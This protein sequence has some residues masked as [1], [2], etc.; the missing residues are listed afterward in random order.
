MMIKKNWGRLISP[1]LI[2][3]IF[4]IN[5]YAS[6]LDID[7]IPKLILENF[8]LKIAKLDQKLAKVELDGSLGDFDVQ[9]ANSIFKSYKN[10]AKATILE[11]PSV[12]QET[13]GFS[14][15]LSKKFTLGTE[16]DFTIQ[17]MN[18]ESNSINTAFESW[19]QSAAFIKI[20]QP[21]LKGL[22]ADAN[23]TKNNQSKYKIKRYNAI[24]KK[25]Y[26][27]L[28]L[29]AYEIFWNISLKDL[30]INLREKNIISY[31]KLNEYYEKAK[32][33]G[34][35]GEIKKVEV[36]SMLANEKSIILLNKNERKNLLLRLNKLLA[37]NYSRI[38]EKFTPNHLLNYKGFY[39]KFNNSPEIVENKMK[40]EEEKIELKK[41]KNSKLP[42]L[43]LSIEYLLPGV[44]Q[45][46][47]NSW[48][49]ISQSFYPNTTIALN[50][51]WSFGNSY[52]QGKYEE[53]LA[54][55]RAQEQT[56]LKISSI[57]NLEAQQNFNDL[58]ELENVFNEGEKQK[59]YFQKKIEIKNKMYQSGAIS[60]IEYNQ[61]IME[62]TD[63]LIQWHQQKINY[64]KTLN[65]NFIKMKN[66]I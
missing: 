50:F 57:E 17:S 23:L 39:K 1:P 35:K 29:N 46:F 10:E 37:S 45:N 19:N 30:E 59:E 47:D 24:Y 18:K 38:G 34:M 11:N 58:N 36:S 63:Q 25:L 16:I 20:N 49:Q 3:L 12:I 31:S 4:S 40:L 42:S 43:N 64:L 13:L 2:C 32:N 33:L 22:G 44:S 54:K 9:L 53:Q 65:L 6:S 60:L 41:F 15:G 7:E 52:V 62:N 66:K 56:M 48:S 28:I 55:V 51:S 5:N 27:E 21:L 61:T 26:Q 8:E 14:F